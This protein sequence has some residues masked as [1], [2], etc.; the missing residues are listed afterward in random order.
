R[1]A[2]RQFV[3]ARMERVTLTDDPAFE[4]DPR[5]QEKH[6]AGSYGIFAGAPRH[7][8]TLRFRSSIAREVASQTWH[9]QQEGRWDGDEYVLQFPYGGGREVVRDVM[10]FVAGVVV[11]GPEGLREGVTQKLREGLATFGTE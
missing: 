5:E 2:F 11:E 7:M 10:R 4:I 8:A 9:P 1:K 6:F 3:L